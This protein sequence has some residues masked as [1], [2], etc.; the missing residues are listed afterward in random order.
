MCCEAQDD[1]LNRTCRFET[2]WPKGGQGGEWARKDG[3][4][5]GL[6]GMS[7][8]SVLEGGKSQFKLNLGSICM[9]QSRKTRSNA[10]D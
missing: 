6:H 9:M 2:V 3:G 7:S 10:S 5:D 1:Y 4:G 8:S